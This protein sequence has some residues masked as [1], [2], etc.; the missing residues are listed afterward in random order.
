MIYLVNMLLTS[1]YFY[2]ISTGVWPISW[3]NLKE[4]NKKI[5]KMIGVTANSGSLMPLPGRQI[6]GDSESRRELRWVDLD[7]RFTVIDSDR[8]KIQDR[9]S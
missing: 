2:I 4:E 5:R 9:L 8:Q 3:W 1:L 7:D 6:E